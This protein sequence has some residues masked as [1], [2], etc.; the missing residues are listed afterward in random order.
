MA[1]VSQRLLARFQRAPGRF[2][3]AL[4]RAWTRSFCAQRFLQ[5]PNMQTAIFD[6]ELSTARGVD[7]VM[8][9]SNFES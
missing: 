8:R 9:S 5:K 2:L 1:F 3:R 4:L 7:V 6:P